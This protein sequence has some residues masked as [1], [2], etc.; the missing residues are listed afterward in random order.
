MQ[1]QLQQSASMVFEYE[2]ML[3]SMFAYHLGSLQGHSPS[4]ILEL[5]L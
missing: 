5:K 2:K 4:R 3:K 1:Q